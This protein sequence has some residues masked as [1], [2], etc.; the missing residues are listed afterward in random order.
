MYDRIHM[1]IS[2]KGQIIGFSAEQQALF[3]SQLEERTRALTHSVEEL[4][5]RLRAEEAKDNALQRMNSFLNSIWNNADAI[6]MV[7]SPEGYIRYFNPTAERLLGYRAVDVI[8]IES[9]LLFHDVA[10]METRAAEFSLQLQQIV[11]PGLDT[12]TIRAKLN[13]PNEYEWN[14]LR[15]DGTKLPVSLTISAIRNANQITGYVG[16]AIDI[17]EKKS[18]EAELRQALEKEKELNELKSRFVSLASHE[19]R[20]P[21]S[22]I[23]SSVYLISQYQTSED[24]LKRDKHIQRIVSSVNMLTDILNDFL[25]VGKIEEGKIQVRNSTFEPGKLIGTVISEMQGLQKASQQV[26]YTHEGEQEAML[27][28]GLLK[29]IVMNLVS[30]AIKFSP[31]GSVITVRSNSDHRHHLQLYVRDNG[32]GISEEDRQHLFERFFR[33]S[34]VSHIQGTG[35]GLHIVSRYTEIMGGNIECHSRINEGTEFIVT[36]PVREI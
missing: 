16:I 6:M 34:N 5:N 3:D 19:F 17:S 2:N 7:F 24:Q 27:D 32:I 28:P 13:M 20:T 26:A 23:L 29:H 18:A 25:S 12:L 4:K 11:D 9:P 22:T 31:E 8:E 36:F 10:E 15:R 1:T 33:G 30:N 14:Y 35:L 21:L